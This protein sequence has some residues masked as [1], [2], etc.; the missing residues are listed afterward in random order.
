MITKIALF[1]L[2]S[3]MSYLVADIMISKNIN[4]KVAKYL[5]YKSD[6]YYEELMRRYEKNK[7]IK[8]TSKFNIYH[9]I[10]VLIEKAGIRRGL[11]INSLT[12]FLLCIVT[13]ILCYI[14]VFNSFKIMFLSLVISLPGIFI[15]VFILSMI[16][17][18][19]SKK[20]ERV[21]LNF[22]LQLKNYTQINNDIVYAFKQ[23]KTI[24]PLQSYIKKFLV[25]INSGIKFEKAIENLKD[26]ITFEKLNQVLTNM[27]YCYLNGGNLTEL[28][29]RNYKII[30]KIQ[31][32]KNA[33]EQETMGARIVL[34][35]LI[36]LDLFVYFTFIKNDYDNYLIM[37]KSLIGNLILYWNFISIWLLVLL[38]N[39]VK[40]LDY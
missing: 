4:D 25:E 36:I 15:P 26:K 34:V 37:T 18:Y 20:I 17:E 23:V 5:K 33:R 22:L 38:M 12:I 1:I 24:E 2:I 10:D 40:K 9:K 6:K 3:V 16:G 8:V 35:I 21:M 30:A 7:R 27:Q 31:N 32:E 29:S 39:K 19:K 14:L 28:I 13:F 11:L